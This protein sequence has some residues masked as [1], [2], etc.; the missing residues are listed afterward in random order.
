MEALRSS[1][2]SILTRATRR[3]IPEDGILHGLWYL[4]CIPEGFLV[5]A[6]NS[7]AKWN[8]GRKGLCHVWKMRRRAKHWKYLPE[9]WCIPPNLPTLA[10]S[11]NKFVCRIYREWKSAAEISTSAE[12]KKTW[13]YTSTTPYVLMTWSLV[14][15]RGNFACPLPF[16]HRFYKSEVWC[17]NLSNL[18]QIKFRNYC[19]SSDWSLW[20]SAWRLYCLT[21]IKENTIFRPDCRKTS[22]PHGTTSQKMVPLQSQRWEPQISNSNNCVVYVF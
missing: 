14:K 6:I 15:Y 21:F 1:E 16:M 22:A 5:W 9:I 2:T 3:N 17:L 4:S 13:I 12:V 10:T 18:E 8:C 11:Q 20:H 7:Q 19:G